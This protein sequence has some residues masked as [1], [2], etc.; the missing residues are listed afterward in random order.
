MDGI[1]IIISQLDVPALTA[2]ASFLDHDIVIAA[3]TLLL[4]LV[5]ERRKNKVGKVILA[6]A[7]AVILG[8]AVKDL[9]HIDRPC[10]TVP[11]K[12]ACPDSYS[13][14]SG[15]TLLTFTVALAFLN[16]KEFPFYLAFAVF[17]AFTRI[18]LGVHSFE[19]VAG[20]MALAP[21]VYYLA[22]SM[23]GR[24]SN[25]LEGRKYAFGS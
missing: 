12:I 1:S 22:D 23:W 6:M 2:I 21:F 18:Y 11:A 17:V 13:F 16:K 20:S 15:H 8:T 19:D 7:L 10:V 14:P 4:V 25:F 5:F 24:I 3:V 9:V